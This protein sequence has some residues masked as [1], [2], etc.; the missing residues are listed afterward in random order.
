MSHLQLDDGSIITDHTSILCHVRQ[1]HTELYSSDP[2]DVT[3]QDD[4]MFSHK[5]GIVSKRIAS[6]LL[7]RIISSFP[8]L[9]CSSIQSFFNN[10]GV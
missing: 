10:D 9:W 3:A 7:E 2:V 8:V 4:Y 1:F 5:L 6:S